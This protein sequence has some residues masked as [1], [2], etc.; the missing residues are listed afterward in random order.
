MTNEGS[1]DEIEQ[2]LK[3]AFA[4]HNQGRLSDAAA[5]YRSVLVREP[6]QFDALHFLGVIAYQTNDL[7]EADKLISA[8]INVNPNSPSA[9]SNRGSVLR[10]LRRF[11]EAVVD[12]RKAISLDPR[13]AELYINCGNVLQD[14]G[15]FKQAIDCYDKAIRL[16]P[17]LAV[18]HNHRG[19]ALRGAKRFVE[20]LHA[21]D[22]AISLDPRYA[23]AYNNRGM[24]LQDLK[25]LDEALASYDQA[26]SLN[27]AY[28]EA[29]NNRGDLLLKLK[30]LDE[31]FASCGR[32]ITLKPDRPETYVI[33]GDALLGLKR[34]GEALV[35]Y[36]KAIELKPDYAEAYNDRGNVL[37]ELM[38][39]DEA[40]DSCNKAISLDSTFTEAY[41]NRGI[42]LYHLERFDEAL[43]SSNKAIALNPAFAAAYCNVACV[44][45]RLNHFD[46]ALANCDKA[47]A[48][49]RDYADAYR[50]H[51]DVLKDLNRLDEA[52]VSLNKAVALEPD[53]VKARFNRSLT[54][55]L[56]GDFK[57]GWPDYEWRKKLAKPIAARSFP[58]P[59]WSGGEDL[60]GKTVFVHWEQ[61]FGDTLQFYRYA[62]LVRTRGARVILSVQ[63][64]LVRLLK[65]LEPEIEIIGGDERPTDFDRHS[66]LISLPFAFGTTLETIPAQRQYL[67]A[68]P[69]DRAR[70]EAR[71]SKTTRPRIGLAWSGNA[72][73]ENDHNRSVELKQLEPLLSYDAEWVCLQKEVRDSDAATMTQFDQLRF[74]G[75]G[76]RDYGD[77][78]ALIDHLDLVIT[79]DTSVAHLAGAMGKPAW[80]LLPFSPDWRWL[81]DREDSPWYPS[82]R[83]FR[84]PA[85]NDWASVINR[86]KTQVASRFG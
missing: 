52:L 25:R 72:H 58:R 38:R 66:P 17:D 85:I 56:G 41:N 55:L 54:F 79:V 19:A 53:Y 61:G 29:H 9:Y 23:D 63:D 35:H 28:A 69:A 32:A 78:A 49:E 24:V 74:F 57:S 31:A 26:V 2:R 70:W 65:Q 60:A 82:A 14:L 67:S 73:H 51:G 4:F 50:V 81:L 10:D 1:S 83:L 27:P 37:L 46:E 43:A 59:H 20:A 36:D 62:Q 34:L 80:I 33:S 12:Y 21:Y 42:A 15:R 7:I 47:I 75:D 22:K 13:R 5:I 64:P 3:R 68:D 39:L 40:L 6:A 77:T 16:K 11:Q 48:L 45:F 71:L 30:R 84:Q 76:L 44:L 18:A 8:A 86:V